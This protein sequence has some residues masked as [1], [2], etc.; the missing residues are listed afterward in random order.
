MKKNIGRHLRI[1]QQI[2]EGEKTLQ[3]IGL[4]HGVSKQRVRQIG[5]LYNANK[6][7]I[8]RIRREKVVTALKV[9]FKEQKT[10]QELSKELKMPESRLAGYYHYVTGNSF[11][12]DVRARRNQT[13]V[14]KFVSGKTAKKITEKVSKVLDNPNRVRTVN[15]VYSINTKNNVRRYPNVG[16]RS[17]GGCFLDKKILKFIATEYMKLKTCDEIAQVLNDKKL[18]TTHGLQFTAGNIF[19]YINKMRTGHILI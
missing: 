5:C 11:Y 9:G 7:E 19:S 16:D 13:I 10:I 17:K 12:Q 18:T 8:K 1:V 14:E 15:Q 3:E 6:S 2:L 4:E